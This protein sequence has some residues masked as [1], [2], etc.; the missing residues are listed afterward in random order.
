MNWRL[1]ENRERDGVDSRLSDLERQLHKLSGKWNSVGSED[2]AI[3]ACSGVQSELPG[4]RLDS[5]PTV[6]EDPRD[7]IRPYRGPT[8]SDF[9]FQVASGGSQ[10][11]QRCSGEGAARS[12][13][14]EI[15]SIVSSEI[16]AAS[17]PLARLV[18]NDPLQE[19]K[20]SEVTRLVSVFNSG[21]GLLYPIVE[22]AELLQTAEHVFQLLRESEKPQPMQT[23]LETAEELNS[24]KTVT[25]K[26]VI[27]NALALESRKISRLAQRI[28]NS[29]RESLGSS[30]WSL[31]SL[32]GI[33]N[34]ILVV[35]P[36]TSTAGRTHLL[37]FSRPFFISTLTRN[38]RLP[39][40]L[41]TLQGCVSKWES[42]GK[43]RI[44][45]LRRLKMLS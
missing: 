21:P 2:C 12:G 34:W 38:Y 1:I 30:F 33:V 10:P 16:L 13:G 24:T 27:T 6:K 39:A 32:G 4:V 15:N 31:P 14:F 19:M 35:C 37:T 29:V 23:Q 9:S 45:P 7:Q 44:A 41:P 17:K 11:L 5:K 28:F 3:N 26:L 43:T 40:S 20:F 18:F 36:G 8:S 22:T 25:L 42:T